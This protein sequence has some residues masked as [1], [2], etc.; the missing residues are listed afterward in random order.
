MLPGYL[1]IHSELRIL[2]SLSCCC[3][4]S[5]GSEKY[6][7]EII[8]REMYEFLPLLMQF[9]ENKTVFFADNCFK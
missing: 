6:E 7:W 9:R 2:T 4:Y 8:K 5:L 3:D 1:T